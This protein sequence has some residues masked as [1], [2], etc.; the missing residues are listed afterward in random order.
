MFA[1]AFLVLFKQ[2]HWQRWL[3]FMSKLVNIFIFIYAKSTLRNMGFIDSIVQTVY[4]Y[5]SCIDVYD[6]HWNHIPNINRKSM[7]KLLS[8]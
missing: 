8:P 7:Y 1:L 6:Q 2:L 5:L 3:S 4:L